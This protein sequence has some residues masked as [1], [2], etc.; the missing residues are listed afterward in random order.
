M[1]HD[2]DRSRA[3]VFVVGCP[4]SGTTLLYHMLISAGGFVNYRSESHVFNVLAPKYG[5]LDDRSS[6]QR[7]MQEWV[8][9]GYFARSGLK[10]ELIT[11]RV[12][13]HARNWGDFLRLVMESMAAR[14]EV[15]RWAE[16]TPHHVLHLEEIA[17][18]IPDA[19]VI[20][21]VRDGRDV[22][23][24]MD[25]LAWIRPL[26]G[27]RSPTVM[28]AGAYWNWM[29]GAG[30]TAL[31]RSSVPSVEVRFE[32]LVLQPRKVLSGLGEF[33][34]QEL[35]YDRI[36]ENAIGSV[37]RPNSSFSQPEEKVADFNP[38]GRWRESM[39]PEVREAFDEKFGARLEELGY[40]SKQA[41][42]NSHNSVYAMLYSGYF[43]V[44]QWAKTR[45]PLGRILVRTLMGDGPGRT[46]NVMTPQENQAQSA[47]PGE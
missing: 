27:D 35:D 6:R 38:V 24:S 40:G 42:A 2:G 10:K 37:A 41:A 15:D 17:A 16:C 1:T 14:Q 26:P 18:T 45:T 30:R 22:A 21:M 39:T 20:H 3:P 7:F 4:R 47:T 9:T 46:R 11:R 12:V 13:E 33:L 29:L 19:V 36:Q 28:A 43:S 5:S 31:A 32:D 34:D 8:R 44:K 25:R 23:L